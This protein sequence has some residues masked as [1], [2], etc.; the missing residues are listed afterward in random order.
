MSE[1]ANTPPL[2]TDDEWAATIRYAEE[3]AGEIERTSP[4]LPMSVIGKALFD[5]AN[6]TNRALAESYRAQQGFGPR[7]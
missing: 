1:P 2:P 4:R 3:H 5:M 6:A 7:L